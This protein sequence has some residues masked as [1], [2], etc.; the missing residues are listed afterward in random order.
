MVIDRMVNMKMDDSYAK[1]S[2]KVPAAALHGYPVSNNN[3]MSI[4]LTITFY[5]RHCGG[6]WQFAIVSATKLTTFDPFHLP[7]LLQAKVANKTLINWK[8]PHVLKDGVLIGS[9]NTTVFLVD[10]ETGD[11]ISTFKSD[12]TLSFEQSSI[13]L[14]KVLQRDLTFVNF[15]YS[16]DLT[17]TDI[18]GKSLVHDVGQSYTLVFHVRLSRDFESILKTIDGG[19]KYY[20]MPPDHESSLFSPAQLSESVLVN[21]P[22][23][24]HQLALYIPPIPHQPNDKHAKDVSATHGILASI[25]M[26]VLELLPVALSIFIPLIVCYWNFGRR[27]RNKLN[28]TVMVAKVQ[29][30]TPKKKKPQK[31][32]KSRVD[33]NTEKIMNGFQFTGRVYDALRVAVK[34]IVKVY[35]E[36]A[37]KEIQN[38]IESDQHTNIVRWHGVEYD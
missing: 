9:K 15:S 7:F 3:E 12:A 36:V 18:K 2:H 38:L 5:S 11:V 14:K 26:W 10:P 30:V 8:T 33:A 31:S 1:Y 29:N 22:E 37:S 20:L 23:N 19:E 27:K 32:G 34:R 6:V 35:H 28:E 17:I 4:D 25:K 13:I 24:P 21:D 16:R